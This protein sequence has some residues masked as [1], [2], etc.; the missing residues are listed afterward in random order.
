VK[1][2]SFTCLHCGAVR[3]HKQKGKLYCDRVCFQAANKGKHV[4]RGSKTVQLTAGVR[5]NGRGPY[6]AS[7]NP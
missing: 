2:H 1:M 5:Y 4:Q 3:E 7:G 6:S